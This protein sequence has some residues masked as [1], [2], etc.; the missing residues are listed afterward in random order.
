MIVVF[1]I[2]AIPLFVEQFSLDFNVYPILLQF[3][4]IVHT[5]THTQ[6]WCENWNET[7]NERSKK[8]N[9]NRSSEHTISKRNVFVHVQFRIP[10]FE[11]PNISLTFDAAIPLLVAILSILSRSISLRAFFV[12]AVYNRGPLPKLQVVA[13]WIY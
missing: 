4:F 3:L 12:V 5:H 8:K 10:I 9:Q 2:D 11:N 13:K 6:Q 1:G 7:T